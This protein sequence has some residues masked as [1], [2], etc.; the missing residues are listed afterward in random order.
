MKV[1]DPDVTVRPFDDEARERVAA[2]ARRQAKANGLLMQVINFAGGQVEDGL[3]FLPKGTRTQIE[4]AARKALTRSYEMASRSRTGLP[5]RVSGDRAHKVLGTISGAIGG[6]GGLPTALA[7]LPVA[8]TLIFRAVLEVAEA[9][10]EDPL[11]EETRLECLRVFGAGGPGAG[12]DGVDTS[13]IGARLTLS[14]AALNGLISRVAPKFA[15]VLSQ[16][17]ATQTVPVLGAAAGAGTNYAFVDYYVAM[18]HVHFGLR[19]AARD[20]G[21]DK[22]LDHFHKVLAERRVPVNRA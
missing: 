21:E 10:G 5:G 18:A 15:A 19:A 2:L 3:K 4:T 22:V 7:E 9:H 12:D 1:I 14:G 6:L 16:K 11:S 20:Y 13:F 8:T 17:L